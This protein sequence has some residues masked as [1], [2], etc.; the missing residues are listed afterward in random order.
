[1]PGP[2]PQSTRFLLIRHAETVWNAR[3]LW[4]GHQDS[5][6]T[7]RGRDQAE[8]LAEALSGERIDRLVCSDLGRCQQ[9]A[10][11]LVAV[12]GLRL[13]LASQLRE[14]DVSRWSGLS[15]SQIAVRDQDTL[16]R[17][18]A[19]EDVRPGGGEKRSELSKRV[20]AFVAGLALESPGACIALVTHSGVVRALNPGVQAENA[21]ACRR[22]FAE[23]HAARH[24]AI[25]SL[26]RV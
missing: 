3:G 9:T 5:P 8:S 17:F 12:T 20:H 1:M 19:R 15:R 4:Q 21:K 6:L 7:P 24:A 23:I 13:E 25:S 18:D 16:L 26:D 14:L 2:T 10:A 22:T 11:P